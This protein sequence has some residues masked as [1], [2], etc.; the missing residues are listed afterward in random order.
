LKAV[1]V[2]Q[3]SKP[4]SNSHKNEIISIANFI[5]K[6]AEGEGLADPDTLGLFGWISK[7]LNNCELSN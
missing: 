2:T 1:A 7:A 5:E 4:L 3:L 6:D